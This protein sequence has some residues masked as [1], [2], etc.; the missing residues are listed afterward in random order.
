MML[1]PVEEAQGLLDGGPA[2]GQQVADTPQ[3][4]PLLPL[5]PSLA[6]VWALQGHCCNPLKRTAL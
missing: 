4:G 5:R 6:V 3:L 1:S 2:Q